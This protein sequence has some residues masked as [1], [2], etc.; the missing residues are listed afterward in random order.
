MSLSNKENKKQFLRFKK[1]LLIVTPIL[2]AFI[3]LYLIFQSKFEVHLDKEK[4]KDLNIVLITI[5]T[6]RWDYVSAYSSCKA[7]TPNLDSLAEEGTQ[8][9][10]CI[11]QIP[12]TLPS[13]ATILSGAYPL[14]HHVS[15]NSGF[16]VPGQLQLVSEILK[17][18]GFLTSAVIGSYVLNRKTGMNQGFDHYADEFDVGGHI[19]SPESL[20]KRADEVLVE[21]RE[22]LLNNKNHKFFTW[23]HLFDPHTPYTPPSPYKEKF[24]DNPYRGEV[25]YTDSQLGRFIAFLKEEGLYDNCLIVVT[26]DHGEGLGDHGEQEHGFFLYESTVRVPLIISAPFNFPVKIVEQ[27]V[28]HVDLMPTI[29]DMLDVPIPEFCQGRSFLDLMFRQKRDKANI[30]YSE[31]YYPRRHFGWSEL[32]ALY[33]NNWKYIKAPKEELYNL[34]Q[35]TSETNNVILLKS[36]EKEKLNREMQR[37]IQEKSITSLTAARRKGLNKEEIKRLTALGYLTSVVNTTGKL[38][39]PDPKDKIQVVINLEKAKKHFD[40]ENYDLAIPLVKA[41]IGSNPGVILAFHLLGNCYFQKEMFAEALENYRYVLTQ[42]PDFII[43]AYDVI[44]CFSRMG[45]IDVAIEEAK[46]FLMT[47][48]GDYTLLGKLASLYYSRREYDQA[49]DILKKL[50]QMNETDPEVLRL[51]VNVSIIREDFENARVFVERGLEINARL[52]QAHFLLGQ[53]ESAQGNSLKAIALYKDELA[54]NPRNS[55][56]AFYLA[57]ELRLSGSYPVAISYYRKTI[58][59]DPSFNVPYFVIAKYLLMKNVQISEAIRLCKKGT[60]IEPKNQYTIL[61]YSLLMQIYSKLGDQEKADFYAAEAKRLQALLG[62]VTGQQ[63]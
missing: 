1:Y 54:I 11:A 61:G 25:E 34:S 7:Q 41:V 48:P 56:A 6:L 37:F 55:Q 63:E 46:K 13:H 42:R 50:H 26:S 47:Y 59:L 40:R 15:D 49:I 17:N 51:I 52:P 60:E 20:Q 19:F 5:D 38:D 33:W 57:E 2:A 31:T 3:V 9:K 62:Q 12:L 43:V 30:A 29:L 21:A 16:Q 27:T 35:D 10:T 53:I 45:K 28:E 23:I 18:Y 44:E 24:P 4:L 32:K 22:W 14:C 39:L 36:R 8:F 58:E